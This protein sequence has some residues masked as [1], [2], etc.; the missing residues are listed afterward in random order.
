MSPSPQMSQSSPPARC[1]TYGHATLHGALLKAS[2]PAWLRVLACPQCPAVAWA[3]GAEAHD[4]VPDD[5]CLRTCTPSLS[6]RA[7]FQNLRRIGLTR[8]SLMLCPPSPSPHP[9][10]LFSCG[11][12]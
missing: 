9:D 5:T 8:P 10:S 12:C 11:A 7:N 3:W 4:S 2:P 1:S 6:L